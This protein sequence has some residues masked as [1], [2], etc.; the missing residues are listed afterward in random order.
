MTLLSLALS[1]A[2]IVPEDAIAVLD[3]HLCRTQYFR[4]LHQILDWLAIAMNS[5]AVIDNHFI[6]VEFEMEL[7]AEKRETLTKLLLDLIGKKQQRAE[8]LQRMMQE[9][10]TGKEKEQEN[11]WL[12]QYQKLLDSKPKGLEAAEDKLDSKVNFIWIYFQTCSKLCII[13]EGNF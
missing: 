6:Q 13:L 12:I 10:E 2:S 8:D 3:L 1:L 9:M 4:F 7:M 5:T 11:Y